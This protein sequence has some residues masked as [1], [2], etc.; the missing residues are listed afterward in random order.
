MAIPE[1]YKGVL[2]NLRTAVHRNELALV[3]CKTAD[4]KEPVIVVAAI[5]KTVEGDIEILPLAKCFDNNPY[6]ELIPPGDP[7][8]DE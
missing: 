4:T 8:E 1:S 5:A 7:V 2:Q 3:E 6:D